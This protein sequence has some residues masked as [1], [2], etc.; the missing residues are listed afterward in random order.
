VGQGIQILNLRP[1]GIVDH[2]SVLAIR[3]TEDFLERF[4]LRELDHGKIKFLAADE[5]NCAA[6]FQSAV[7]KHGDVRT[8]ESDLDARVGGLDL[9]GQLDVTRKAR[10][11]GIEHQEFVV[12]GNLD[13]LFRRDVMGRG[14]E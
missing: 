5:I 1:V 2:G 8:D 4:A 3:H 10:S 11:A 14:I 13:G 6:I 9:G 7:G 12:L